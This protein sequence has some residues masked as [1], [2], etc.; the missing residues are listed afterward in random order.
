MLS[1]YL[2]LKIDHLCHND[3]DKE[4]TKRHFAIFEGWTKDLKLVD[5]KKLFQNK[6]VYKLPST[7]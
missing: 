6:I 1:H 5:D 4:E 7:L 3:I 2:L